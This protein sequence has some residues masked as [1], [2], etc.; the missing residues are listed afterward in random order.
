MPRDRRTAAKGPYLAVG[1]GTAAGLL[2]GLAWS[3]GRRAAAGAATPESL[4]R[5][6]ARVVDALEAEGLLLR[7]DLEVGALGDGI[8]EVAGTVR[9]DDEADRVVAAARRVPGV[10]TIL[11]R[12]DTEILAAHLA[13][14]RA[15][16]AV[17]GPGERETHWY[18]NRV[19][20]GIRRQGHETDP[21]R[22]DDRVPIVSR[23][24]GAGRAVEATAEEL[25]K[26]AP[27]VEGHTTVPAAPTDRGAV[28]DAPHGRLGNVPREP[29]QELHP[30]AGIHENVKKGTELTLEE[31]GLEEELIERDL[32]DRS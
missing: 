8:I 2:A 21:D 18:G 14:T 23:E 6:E 31:T 28:D 10:R 12:L 22:P 4:A 26:L 3:R 17:R 32:K 24:L 20:T 7:R 11:N 19:G 30:E 29:I 1:I 27:G 25:D 13:E 16:N 15:R 9:D 5:L